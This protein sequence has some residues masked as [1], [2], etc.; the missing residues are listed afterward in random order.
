M[1]LDVAGVGS[2]ARVVELV[3]VVVVGV[4]SEVQAQLHVQAMSLLTL[5]P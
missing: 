5:T 1:G 4:Q 3:V 2:E